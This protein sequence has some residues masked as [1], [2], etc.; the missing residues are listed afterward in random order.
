MDS[1]PLLAYVLNDRYDWL[2]ACAAERN[3]A[4]SAMCSA[5]TFRTGTV[6]AVIAWKLVAL[7]LLPAA[8]CC[9]AVMVA[10]GTTDV[11]ACCGGGGH[12]ATCPMKRAGRTDEQDTARDA[13]RMIGCNS[14]DDA[15]V[16]LFNLTGFTPDAFE[17]TAGPALFERI[18][19]TRYRVASLTGAPSP[20][21]PRVQG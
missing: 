9:Q 12:G 2:R 3:R 15:L 14:L 20:P 6:A 1:G 13:P 19:E 4:S 16:G 21:P 18:T 11:P 10:D 17:W 7:A 5:R 8:L